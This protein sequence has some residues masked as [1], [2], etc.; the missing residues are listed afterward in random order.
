MNSWK[1]FEGVEFRNSRSNSF[2]K[3]GQKASAAETLKR[4]SNTK[5][6]GN[7][8][9]IFRI[10]ERFRI[11]DVSLGVWFRK[12]RTKTCKPLYIS[13]FQGSLYEM[14]TL[15]C[16]CG[17]GVDEMTTF[18]GLVVFELLQFPTVFMFF[19][20]FGTVLCVK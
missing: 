16:M 2:L 12:V 15:S 5:M 17:C 20:S 4:G 19:L 3:K 8:L 14:T 6:N 18:S 1:I 10:S 13:R 7:C 11:S 9:N